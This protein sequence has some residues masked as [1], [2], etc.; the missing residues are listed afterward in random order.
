MVADPFRLGVNYWPAETA[1]GWLASYD[2]AVVRRDFARV[3]AAGMDTVRVF[4]RW[5]DVQP[6]P[7]ALD[8]GAL[9]AL[10]DTADAAAT[11]GVDLVVTLFTGHMSG[12]NWIPPWALGG[13]DGDQRFRVISGG[14]VQATPPS[15]RNWYADPEIV[16]A[17]ALLAAGVAGAL[18]GHPAVWAWD[19]G[20]ES[21]NCTV[22][23]T[24]QT[25]LGWLERMTSTIRAADPGRPITIGLHMEDL[26]EDRRIGPAEAAEWC[27]FVC[28][29]GYPAYADWSTGSADAL[30][31]PFLT[32]ITRWLAGGADV[33][34]EELGQ[35]TTLGAGPIGVQVTE[36]TAASYT[37]QTL[38]RLRS[39]GAIGALLWCFTDYVSALHDDP[40]F[41]TAVHE[42]SFGLWR[43]D[44]TTKPSFDEIAAR[45][46][47]TRAT[48]S[49][50]GDWLDVTA[51]EFNA[52]RSAQLRRLYS[53]YRSSRSAAGLPT[54][55]P[56]SGSPNRRVDEPASERRTQEGTR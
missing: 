23:P 18:A 38:D 53:R 9:G 45:S 33:L 42:R 12:V 40:P 8:T 21:S 44:G 54:G 25:A 48:P 22:P 52:D 19:L 13:G 41:D 4:V 7:S 37:A 15:L 49:L 17:Q 46:R 16:S 50:P 26:E 30:L 51:E 39:A 55:G 32:E 29:H 5:E 36:A 20:N 14:V 27:D 28:M 56:L 31:V 6:A 43:A 1:M 10:V 2:G 3:A 24:R 35:S 11:S 47:M 34:F